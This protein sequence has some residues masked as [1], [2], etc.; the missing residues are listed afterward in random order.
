M[1]PVTAHGYN[2]GLSGQELLARAVL[3]ARHQGQDIGS[4]RLLQQYS[5]RHR[6]VALPMYFG[7]N[8]LV[9]LY[10]TENLPTRIVRKALLHAANHLPPIRRVVTD[11]L[12]SH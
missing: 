7:T 6:R 9:G 10:T 8:A 3:T 1:H 11:R 4:P 5:D 12:V 2:L